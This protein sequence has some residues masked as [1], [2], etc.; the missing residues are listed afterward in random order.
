MVTINFLMHNG[1]R[2]LNQVPDT[3]IPGRGTIPGTPGTHVVRMNT[4]AALYLH[5]YVLIPSSFTHGV[6]AVLK[7]AG[8]KYLFLTSPDFHA[9]TCINI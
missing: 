5:A 2:R 1:D 6:G 8:M 7:H 3:T 4:A 9:R